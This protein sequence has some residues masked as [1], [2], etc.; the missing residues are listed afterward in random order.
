ME[1]KF[2]VGCEVIEVPLALYLLLL[3][4]QI[5]I[6]FHRIE[7][8]FVELADLTLNVHQVARAFLLLHDVVTEDLAT[9]LDNFINILSSV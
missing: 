3:V 5:K 1:I 7:F 9:L 6:L 2:L 4:L 8:L